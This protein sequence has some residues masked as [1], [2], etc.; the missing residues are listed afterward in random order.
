MPLTAHFI[1]VLLAC[2]ESGLHGPERV[3]FD[4]G[5]ATDTD[6]GL[7]DTASPVEVCNG[8]DDDGDGLIDEGF[9]DTDG[10]GTADCVDGDCGIEVWATPSEQH[11]ACEAPLVPSADP[12][13]LEVAWE[14][15]L[16]DGGGCAVYAVGDMDGDGIAEIPCVGLYG[17]SRVLNGADGS[18]EATFGTTYA[19]GSV[20]LGDVDDDGVMDML[21]VANDEH[22]NPGGIEKR[23]QDG[24]V[25]WLGQATMDLHSG[26]P[27]VEVACGSDGSPTVLQRDARMSGTTGLTQASWD[28]DSVGE[29]TVGD[30][31]VADLDGD[32][33]AEILS[34]GAAW[35]MDG[36]LVWSYPFGVGND[37]RA[38]AL[39]QADTDPEPEVFWS[40]DGENA[41]LDGDG[42]LLWA[43]APLERGPQDLPC[44][45][46]VDGDGM[47]DVLFG[48][49]TT[50]YAYSG[51]GTLLWSRAI[52]DQGW[53]AGCSVF[54]FDLDGAVEVLLS[55]ETGFDIL[56]GRTGDVLF[57]DA[58]D[59]ATLFES[60]IVA[61]LDG[62]GSV[63]IL[64]NP[65]LHWV[66]DADVRV[67]RNAHRDWPPGS[68]FWGSS[69]WSGAGKWPDGE[70]RT[71]G[72]NPWDPE[73][74]MWRGQPSQLV[75]GRDLHIELADSCVASC[76]EDGL[77]RIGAVVTNLGP[78]MLRAGKVVI[79]TDSTGNALGTLTLG[80][81]A[82]GGAESVEFELR[83]GDV[84]DGATITVDG[85]DCA[86]SDDRVA[87]VSPCGP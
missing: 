86:Q 74:A 45:G 10:D 65:R 79:A 27:S 14:Y 25:D 17:E 26:Y 4:S 61:D 57:E 60:P 84:A 64:L 40:A 51:S 73:L 15:T 41:L 75:G 43:I 46:D 44:A 53:G 1:A 36:E 83:A 78:Q 82:V 54:D 16:P 6:T 30:L 8:L 5:E 56:D 38:L 37:V 52:N 81:L 21:T 39:L 23:S 85:G 24:T 67:Y 2:S 87:W 72:P 49:R 70:L 28:V 22:G 58:Q 12:W 13:D 59:S 19:Y 55:T 66:S 34:A 11:A 69:T 35:T 47:M 62:D 76:E 32:G 9:P 80:E 3:R 63:E 77:V 50:F 20:A 48:E 68:T 7:V 29:T 71:D 33:T 18:V 31:A 42:S